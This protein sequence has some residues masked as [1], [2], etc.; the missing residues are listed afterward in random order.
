MAFSRGGKKLLAAETGESLPSRRHY[1][2]LAILIGCGLRRAEVTTLR[3]EDFQ[4]RED[5]CVIAD[6]TGKGGHIRTIPVPEWVKTGVD[7]WQ[8]AAGI[9]NGPLFRSINKAGKIWGAG[10]T[11]KVIWAIVKRNATNRGL[12]SVAP[13]DLRRRTC[14]RLCHPAGGELE[15]D[16]ISAAF[17]FKLRRD[18]SGASSDFVTL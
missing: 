10:F 17:R 11:P 12:N 9:D 5:H 6:L 8:L 2:L 4:L 3:C 7:Q 16:P 15:P 13:H 18:T 14:A 1:A